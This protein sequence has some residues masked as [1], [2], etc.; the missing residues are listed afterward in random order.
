MYRLTRHLLD[1]SVT[2]V[3]SAHVV[4]QERVILS[5]MPVMDD[6]ICDRRQSLRISEGR[7]PATTTRVTSLSSSSV[8]MLFVFLGTEYCHLPSIIMRLGRR[9][10]CNLEVEFWQMR[11]LEAQ[12]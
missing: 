5:R 8:S 11:W 10:R 12:T 3:Y 7:Q 9:W 6:A 1:I 2:V 4:Y